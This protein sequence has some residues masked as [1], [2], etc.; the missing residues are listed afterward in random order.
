[1]KKQKKR[2]SLNPVKGTSSAFILS[3]LVHGGLAAVATLIVVFTIKPEPPADFVSPPPVKNPKIALEKLKMPVKTPSKPKASKK[4][5]A[6]LD[7]LAFS[8]ISFPDLPEGGDGPGNSGGGEDGMAFLEIPPLESVAL[9]GHPESTGNDFGGRVYD[10]KFWADGR[11][12][13]MYF[14]EPKMTGYD[15]E[16]EMALLMF[17]KYINEGWK[18][19]VISPYKKSEKL[20]TTHFCFPG[21]PSLIAADQFGQRDLEAFNFMVGYQGSLVYPKDITFRFWCT[22]ASGAVINV[23]GKDVL[24]RCRKSLIDLFDFNWK[25]KEDWKRFQYA[26]SDGYMVAGDWI[27]LKAGEPVPMKVALHARGNNGQI[28]LVILVEEK[29][30]KY[31][32]RAIGGPLLPIFKTEELSHDMLDQIMKY[33]PAGEVNLTN[34]PIFRDF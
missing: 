26:L 17:A 29:G 24:A 30:K 5:T 20:Y 9:F 23:G 34:G 33:L 27:T 6:V 16:C 12:T 28:S 14:E 15:G 1:M 18:T 31:P 2:K 10:F 4:I 11:K 22:A 8:A 13:K 21:V 25:D 32:S 3:L 7:P 19:S